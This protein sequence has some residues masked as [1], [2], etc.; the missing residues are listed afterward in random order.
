MKWKIL[1]RDFTLLWLGQV[2]SQLGDGAGLIGLMWWVQG[3]ERPALALGLIAMVRTLV[4]AAFSPFAGAMVD[5]YDKRRILISMDLVRGAI[6]GTLAWLAFSGRNNL[7]AILCLVGA[8]AAASQLF[9]PAVAA[10]V[11]LL[12]SQAELPQANSLT[13][14]T[15]HA[16]G[17]ISYGLGGILVAVIGVPALLAVDA[18]SF[19]ISACA[20]AF[21]VIPSASASTAVRAKLAA[22][23]SEGLAYVRRHRVL[24]SIM[25]VAAC[26]NF[27]GAPVIVLLPKFVQEI[28]GASPELFGALLSAYM[29]GSLIGTLTVMS[30]KATTRQTGIILHA[31]AIEAALLAVFAVLP[32]GMT[33]LR[34]AL[35]LISGFF[36]SLA[37][38]HLSTAL[39][40]A[41]APEHRGKVFGLLNAI[42]SSLQPVSQG[43][44][45]VLG[46]IIPAATIFLISGAANMVG[47]ELY[48][49]TPGIRE[50]LA[51]SAERSATASQA[52]TD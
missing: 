6:Y 40:K 52:A 29:T 17:I 15:A 44:A 26:T 12:V 10:A 2:V 28:Q 34:I 30:G 31:F 22:G 35:F 21:V 9:N 3:G 4:G 16:V 25:L 27:F 49:A 50:F 38:I 42:S 45:G 39:Q 19:L 24:S 32:S 36:N 48:A 33:T 20:E 14:V 5:R 43:L 47:G 41:T 1:G 51:S 18:I 7:P 37:N 8:N 23:V 11:P 46:D 13:R